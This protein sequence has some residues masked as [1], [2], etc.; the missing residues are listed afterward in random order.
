MNF[1][2][3]MKKEAQKKFTENGALAYDTTTNPLV[4]LFGVIGGL[5][6]RSKEDIEGM[7]RDSFEVDPLLTTKMMFYAGNI[8]GGLGERRTFNI[9]LNWLARYYPEVVEKNIPLIPHFNRYDSLFSLEG[10]PVENSMWEFIADT[11]VDDISKCK[12]GKPCSLLA[13]WLPSENASS[14]ETKRRA[15]KLI[16]VLGVSARSYRKCLSKLRGYI[17]IV[18]KDMSGNKW[19]NIVYSTVPSKAMHNYNKAFFVH[20]SERFK[21]Y[22][23]QVKSG[24]K[25]IN[26]STLFPY[27]L[28]AKYTEDTCNWFYNKPTELN[29]IV[30]LQWKNLPNYVKEDKNVLVMADVS[31]SMIGRP[32]NTAIGL[33]IY[34]AERNK[35]IFHNKFMS[36]SSR[37]RFLSIKENGS[38][39][40]NISIVRSGEWGMSTN[41]AGAFKSILDVAVK[42]RVPNNEM[43]EALVVISDMEIDEYSNPDFDWDFLKMLEEDYALNGYTLPKIVMWNVESRSTTFLTQNPNVLFISGQSPSSF[44]NLLNSLNG[45]SM[46]LVLKTLNDPMYDCVEI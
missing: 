1:A 2:Q 13:K 27:D 29:E 8:R 42:A 18:E 4:D 6:P 10:T 43:P 7:F 33:S 45:T 25:K 23:D 44:S 9:C 12:Q 14:M 28:V 19:D 26:A 16:D 39:K 30:E 37:P 46:D 21:S 40:D 34:F 20:D 38:L 36:F 3:A 15:R 17:K 41:L 32:M 35:G 24:E 11:L 5:R 31:G 22:I